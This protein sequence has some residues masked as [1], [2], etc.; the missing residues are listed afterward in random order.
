MRLESI[1]LESDRLAVFRHRLLELSLGAQSTAEAVVGERVVGL[2]PDRCAIFGD[3]LRHV[4]LGA[5]GVAEIHV[6]IGVV[7]LEPDRRTIFGDGLR[8]I[9][10]GAQGLA[11][12][13]VGIDVVGL[14][15]DLRSQ[16]HNGLLQRL[17]A[18]GISASLKQDTQ[19]SPVPTMSRPES[20]QV[21]EHNHRLIATI[22]DL[23]RMRQLVR[24]LGPQGTGHAV[25]PDRLFGPGGME[26]FEGAPQ[27]VV[28]PK[29]IG[30]MSLS[31]LEQVN[32]RVVLVGLLQCRGQQRRIRRRRVLRIGLLRQ[33][34]PCLALDLA[35]EL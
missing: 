2:D 1:G 26:F 30:M 15:L 35:V 33:L 32:G 29:V 4:P 12:V 3:R 10:L 6:G 14:E 16:S 31:T 25:K 34:E 20:R 24:R 28:D 7:G 18:A 13:V 27:V 22:S 11:E 23:E 19:A 9:S 8:E 21:F 17:R 5:Q